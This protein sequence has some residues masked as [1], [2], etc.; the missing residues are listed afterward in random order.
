MAEVF[1]DLSD[2]FQKMPAGAEKSAL[3]MDIF[4]R[5]GSKMIQ[6]LDNGKSGLQALGSELDSFGGL[7]DE[8]AINQAAEFNDS[9]DRLSATAKAVGKSVGLYLIPIVKAIVDR[10][11]QWIVQ[12]REII[13]TRLAAFMDL[14]AKV[15]KGVWFA[16]E[17]LVNITW[18]L[19]RAIDFLFEKFGGLKFA[20]A[21]VISLLGFFAL[22]KASMGIYSIASA[23]ATLGKAALA[24]NL[25]AAAI[26][27]LIGALVAGVF[28]IIDDF[29]AYLDGRPSVLGFLVKNWD[30]Y[31]AILKQTFDNVVLWLRDTLGKAT[32][33]ILQ[34]FGVPK[35]QADKLA[36]SVQTAFDYTLAALTILFESIAELA[37]MAFDGLGYLIQGLSTA[38]LALMDNPAQAL[39]D[40]GNLVWDTIEGAFLMAADLIENSFINPVTGWFRDLWDGAMAGVDSF[41][42][43][44]QGAFELVKSTVGGI[45]GFFGVNLDGPAGAPSAFSAPVSPFSLPQPAA[46]GQSKLQTNNLNVQVTVPPGTDPQVAGQIVQDALRKELD[47]IFFKTGADISPAVS[48]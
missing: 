28:L 44:V 5:S 3:A 19:A 42:A 34:F 48:Y 11:Q 45:A 17:G 40:F 23:F 10:L 16:F 46:G 24:A 7:M 18:A 39:I 36:A 25:K 41:V 2:A 4:G 22:G 20:L 12:N 13:K 37:G 47:S 38:I 1:Y 14:L 35:E 43:K 26:P 9:L 29:I 27:I 21:A 8:E 30:E 31:S 33:A 32:T 6:T 15:V